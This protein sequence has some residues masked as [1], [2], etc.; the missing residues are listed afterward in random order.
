MNYPVIVVV[1]VLFA[2]VLAP[3]TCNRPSVG[4]EEKIV[5]VAGGTRDA[6]DLPATEAKLHEPFGAEWDKAGNLW[7]VEMIH[8]NRL[9]KVDTAGVLHHVAG[10]FYAESEKKNSQ[11]APGSNTAEKLGDG[12]PPRKARFMG[13]HNL[14][15]VS[16]SRVVV[17]D[18][19]SGRLREFD[20]ERS[21]ITSLSAWQVPLEQ[22]R[23]AGPYCVAVD[24][25]RTKLYVSDLRRVHEVDL[26]TNTTRVVAG[27]GQKGVPIDGAPALESPLVDPRA[28]C[29]D[30]AGRLYILE[31]G[32]N[33]LRVVDQAGRISTVVNASG[34]K[35]MS[36]EKGPALE[37]PMN[38]PKHLCVDPQDRVV[39]ADAENNVIV[40]YDPSEKQIERLA[41]T[42]RSGS[43]GL[44]GSPLKC[45]LARPHGV[46]FHPTTGRLYITDSYNHR[47][48]MIADS[49]Q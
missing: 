32:G 31:R 6:V 3:T 21:T 25:N 40:R 18:T 22:A 17:A 48:L 7:I 28:A 10:E 20:V 12:G 9:L 33:A 23:G 24:F 44:G 2:W 13:P 36:L 29:V 38:G 16:E 30:R 49:S 37:S 46:S 34:K 5:L 26:A 45:S 41:G 35:G 42:G 1:T 14:A 39:I 47:V 27:N 19:W 15:V 8:G 43:A 4:A 11:P